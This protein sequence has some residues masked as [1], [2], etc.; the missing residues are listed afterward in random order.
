MG[1]LNKMIRRVPNTD[2]EK[3]VPYKPVRMSG[4]VVETLNSNPHKSDSLTEQVNTGLMGNDAQYPQDGNWKVETP[5]S[6]RR[7]DITRSGLSDGPA[8]G[9]IP[10]LWQDRNLG[11]DGKDVSTNTQVTNGLL[12]SISGSPAGGQGDAMFI[13][14]ESILRPAG[15]ARGSMRTIDD[16]AM[17]P[18]VFVADPTRR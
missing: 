13:P 8:P 10:Y 9:R 2:S 5:S 14:H 7:Q 3:Q 12:L 17:I 18:G 16:G 1:I 4:T 6:N 15:M 11:R